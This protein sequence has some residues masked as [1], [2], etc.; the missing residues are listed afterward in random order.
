LQETIDG[1]YFVI[2]L[3]KWL[4]ELRP[5]PCYTLAKGIL[6]LSRKVCGIKEDRTDPIKY[7]D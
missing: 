3:V 1:I 6:M 7:T 5:I 4:P 2:Y